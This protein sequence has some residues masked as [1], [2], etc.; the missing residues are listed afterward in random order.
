MDEDGTLRKSIWLKNLGPGYIADAFRW[1]HEADPYAQL[2]YNDYSIEFTGPKS[3]AVYAMVKDLKRN[4]VPIN[5]VGF[6]T[7]LDTQ[8]GFPDLQA[9]L[10]RFAKLGLNVAE[11]EVDIR[12]FVKEKPGTKPKQFTNIPVSGLAQSAQEAYWSQSV[13]ACLA[14]SRCISY[15]VWG[16]ADNSSWIPGVFPGEGAALLYD[17]N[18]NAKPQYR[19]VQQDLRLAAGGPHPRRTGR[20]CP[21]PPWDGRRPRLTSRL[22]SGERRRPPRA[23]PNSVGPA[24]LLT[25]RAFRS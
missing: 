19:V 15:T 25:R 7:H 3:N 21:A 16:V 2:F 9:N 12:T 24:P 14:V 23:L 5:G 18:L 8:Y 20:G 17:D 10:R 6:Q 22:A 4:R 13:Q 1:A 11:T